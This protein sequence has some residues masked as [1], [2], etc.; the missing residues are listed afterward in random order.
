MGPQ[1]TFYI[2]QGSNY[3]LA[4]PLTLPSL[5]VDRTASSSSSSS[6]LSKQNISDDLNHDLKFSRLVIELLLDLWQDDRFFFIQATL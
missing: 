6:S 1:F 3:N 2:Y 4:A 5:E